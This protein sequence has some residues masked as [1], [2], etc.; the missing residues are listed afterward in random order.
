[1]SSRLGRFLLILLVV[2]IS[3]GVNTYGEVSSPEAGYTTA[4]Q[5]LL[6]LWLSV[7][8]VFNVWLPTGVVL[9]A[10]L[11][12][13][14]RYK[15]S[16]EKSAQRT[17]KASL[18]F[19]NGWLDRIIPKL[20]PGENQDFIRSN[21]MLPRG[22]HLEVQCYCNM[23]PSDDKSLRWKRNQGASGFAWDRALALDDE[24]EKRTPVIFLKK[25]AD[26]R[27]LKVIWRLSD[28][29]IDLTKDVKWIVSI[30]L[31]RL[32]RPGS[33]FVGILNFDG[34]DQELSKMEILDTEK[35]NQESLAWGKS[36][37]VQL[38]ERG[39]L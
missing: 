13:E 5:S 18:D 4:W 16:K 20:F 32:R 27:D 39:I 19:M 11:I 31:F 26:P 14:N 10:L 23:E 38:Q 25:K 6:T 15:L 8:G 2:V 17:L 33:E 30:P 3:F 34:V 22:N 29:Q 7:Q 9:G 24:D 35:F 12:A 21:I 1:M 28:E 36:A 37:S